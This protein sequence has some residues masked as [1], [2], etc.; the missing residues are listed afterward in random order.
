MKLAKRLD[1]CAP[2]TEMMIIN[3]EIELLANTT[4]ANELQYISASNQYAVHL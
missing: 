2:N 4:I 1:P 3:G